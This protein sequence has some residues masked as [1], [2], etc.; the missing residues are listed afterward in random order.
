MLRKKFI[1]LL[2]SNSQDMTEGN[3]MKLIL[4]FGLPLLLG[5]IFQQFYNM[6]DAIIVGKVLGVNALAAVGS[7]GSINFMIMGFCIGVCSGFAIPVAQSFGAKNE[8]E[9]KKFITNIVWVSFVFATIFTIIVSLLTKDILIMMK[10]PELIFQDSYIYI[11]II[12]IGT[13]ATFLYNTISGILRSMGNSTV[14]VVCLIF[15]AII[16]IVL[17]FLLIKPMGVAGAAVATVIAQLISGIICVI[18]FIKKYNYL[19][20]E[21]KD[22]KFSPSHALYLCNMGIPMGL[23]YSITGIGCVILQTFVNELGETAVAA[24][25][26]SS[27]IINFASCPYEAMGTTM[28]T[29]G[30]QNVGAKK[31]DRIHQ[32]L[33]DCLKLGIGYGFIAFLF[34]AIFGKSLALLFVDASEIVLIDFIYHFLVS[35]SLFYFLLAFVNIVR[36]M[37]QGL[38]YSTF[39]IIAGVLE[40]VARALTGICLVPIFGYSIV[41]FAGPLAWVAA[42]MFLIP[43]YFY[44]MGKLKRKLVT[45]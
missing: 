14:P 1:S 17:D 45:I 12:F 39:A 25:A 37:I 19:H 4:S 38:G 40:M 24:V 26:A 3:S 13:P 15:S 11:L 42:D 22:W 32:G 44:V 29:Y 16:N 9:L 27:K 31:L 20:F 6:V 7:T 41:P 35:V 30:G 18:Y 43:A 34:M 33:K 8:E 2:Q 28:A 36:F 21:K 10:T 5:L 23:Q